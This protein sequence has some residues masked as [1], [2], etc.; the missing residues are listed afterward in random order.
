[1]SD[2]YE[3]IEDGLWAPLLH[4]KGTAAAPHCCDQCLGNDLE[5]ARFT[6]PSGSASANC[7]SQTVGRVA[8]E[9]DMAAC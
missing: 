6:V 7:R 9:G 5:T 2:L 1:M 3:I 4:S 8:P